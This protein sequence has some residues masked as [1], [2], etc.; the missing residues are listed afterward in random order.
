MSIVFDYSDAYILFKE[1]TTALNTETV[2]VPNNRKKKKFK[3]CALSVDCI[4]EIN[5]AEIDHTKD[6]DAVMPMY[7]L[8][9]YSDTYSKTPGR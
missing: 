9:E 5:N 6:I 4:S 2:A 7:N 3:T 8:I 1:T